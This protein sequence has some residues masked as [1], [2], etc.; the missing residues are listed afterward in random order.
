MNIDL[1]N[2]YNELVTQFVVTT[3]PIV[4]KRLA[5]NFKKNTDEKKLEE[6]YSNYYSN[7]LEQIGYIKPIYDRKN[8]IPITDLYVPMLLRDS[9]N[10]KYNPENPSELLRLHPKFININGSGGI[11]KTT[12]VKTLV[13]QLLQQKMFAPIYIEIRKFNP[14]ETTDIDDLLLFILNSMN[15]FDIDIISFK[16]LISNGKHVFIIDGFDEIRYEHQLIIY[17]KLEALRN[18][19]TN[20]HFIITSR[21]IEMM[22]NGWTNSIILYVEP[23]NLVQ[24]K[25]MITKIKT[26][27]D[28]KKDSFL[29]LLDDDS[30]TNINN[31]FLSNPLLLSIMLMTFDRFS[32]I[33]EKKHVFYEKAYQTLYSE[34]DSNKGSMFKREKLLE[35]DGMSEEEI[36]R[37]IGAFSL[38]S[39]CQG[40]YSFENRDKFFVFIEAVRKNQDKLLTLPVFKNESFERDIID[41]ICLLLKDGEEIKY[42]H[43]SFQEYFAASCIL[44]LTAPKQKEILENL[45]IVNPES[46]K[47]DE[48]FNMI[49]DM[50]KDIIDTVFFLPLLEATFKKEDKRV[51]SNY[52]MNHYTQVYLELKKQIIAILVQEKE[53]HNEFLSGSEI[54][55]YNIEQLVNES[56]KIEQLIE[57]GDKMPSTYVSNSN[58]SEK[59][60]LELLKNK[61]EKD[62]GIFPFYSYTDEIRFIINIILNELINIDV[63]DNKYSEFCSLIYTKLTSEKNTTEDIIGIIEEYYV[64]DTLLQNI[65]D[66]NDPEKLNQQ[67]K[68]YFTV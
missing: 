50:N 17:Q 19:Y 54:K 47:S 1:T 12:I 36:K 8:P 29:E 51:L 2:T 45:L 67:N 39:Y 48:F 28:E 46:F 66:K 22:K 56:R 31:E 65:K 57:T 38:I 32:E 63:T 41:S 59:I 27:D 16:D 53:V 55:L 60:V 33:P 21:D 20:N 61:F 68:G 9:K 58:S 25:Q 40:T 10:K 14:N 35:K 62:L 37:V 26:F 11:G 44:D 13:I 4:Y 52:I 49:Y 30:F 7:L 43:R 18:A 6:S 23:F 5:N 24:S 3:I 15:N 64:I 34:H 42:I